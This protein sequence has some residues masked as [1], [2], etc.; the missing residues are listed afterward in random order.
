MIEWI[1]SN[2]PTN[3]EEKESKVNLFVYR[4]MIKDLEK[5]HPSKWGLISNGDLQCIKDT[6][7]EIAREID[8]RNLLGIPCLMFQIG[9]K[10]KKRTFGIGSRI[11]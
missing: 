1:K 3:R 10:M 9:V 7:E 2:E 6:R 8:E 11:K 4:T 5:S